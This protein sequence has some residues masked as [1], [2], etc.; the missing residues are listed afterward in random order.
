MKEQD[1]AFGKCDGCE[2]PF[3][4]GN[5]LVSFTRV[6]AQVDW[7]PEHPEGIITVIDGKPI[8]PLCA[9]CGNDAIIRWEQT[10]AL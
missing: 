3:F 1:E 10:S 4:F 2:K 7:T 9:R 5:A 6:F 8:L